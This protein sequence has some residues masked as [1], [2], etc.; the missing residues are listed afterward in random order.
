MFP[1]VTL[2]STSDWVKA[3]SFHVLSNSL[4]TNYLCIGLPRVLFL[5]GFPTK[6]LSAFSSL[7]YVLRTRPSHLSWFDEP[8]LYLT[9]VIMKLIMN[10]F[11]RSFVTSYI[12]GSLSSSSVK[13]SFL[14]VL[15]PATSCHSVQKPCH[16]W[17]GYSPGSTAAVSVWSQIR[18]RF[19]AST[20]DSLAN[21]FP[22]STPYSSIIQGWYNGPI[23]GQ[24]TQW[25][26]LQISPR[27]RK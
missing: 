25:T 27:I 4:F 10:I 12:L 18:G 15:F 23:S 11:R 17:S 19:P 6:M 8:N 16:C 20:S 21:S 3:S 13:G 2:G 14:W 1:S 7:P 5:S 9:C 24:S 26:L 22:Q